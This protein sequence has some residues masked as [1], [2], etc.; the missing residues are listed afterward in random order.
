MNRLCAAAACMVL[1]AVFSGCSDKKKD[2]SAGKESEEIISPRTVTFEWQEPYMAKLEEFRS[3]ADYQESNGIAG[4]MFDLRDL[5]SDGTPELVISPSADAGEKCSVYTFSGGAVKEVGKTGNNGF[6][7]FYFD[8]GLMNDEF[9]GEGFVM[10]EYK[11]YVAGAFFTELTYYKNIDSAASGAVIR[12]EIDKSEVTLTEYNDKI[13]NISSQPYL[14]VGRKYTFGE[15]TTDYAIYCAES[16]DDVASASMK[17]AMKGKIKELIGEYGSASAFELVDM[18][19]DE[20][21]ELIFSEG[22]SEEKACRLFVYRD[23][24]LVEGEGK[25]G[26]NGRFGFD[27]EKLVFFT[28]NPRTVEQIGS[29][30]G[31]SLDDYEKSD[32]L[33]EC[34]RKYPATE[35]A[36]AALFG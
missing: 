33:M 35:E 24:E 3:S 28:I 36:V 8:S 34:G 6:I 31:S 13:Y 29:L 16:W 18:D 23:G 17:S 22:N 9:Q 21:P 30:T 20:C 26:I 11:R 2:D 12:Y 15:K 1:A 32:S 14:A 7:T 25:Y 4:S 5:D 27:N 10:G 19:G